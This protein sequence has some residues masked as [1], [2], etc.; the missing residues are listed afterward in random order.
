MPEEYRVKAVAI[1]ACLA[2]IYIMYLRLKAKISPWIAFVPAIISII[3]IA[4]IF[5]HL[6]RYTPYDMAVR[7]CGFIS[8]LWYIV[9]LTKVK[10]EE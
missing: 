4:D 5:M 3:T 10:Y 9:L 8:G 1:I 6:D 2:F 7:F